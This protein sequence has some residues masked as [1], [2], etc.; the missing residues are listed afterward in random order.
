MHFA[1][2][3]ETNTNP[4]HHRLKEKKTSNG[5][6]RGIHHIYF[7]SAARRNNCNSSDRKLISIRGM[8]TSLRTR[9]TYLVQR[10]SIVIHKQ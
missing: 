1:T 3:T 4:V 2:T 5:E 9:F 8:E 6:M 10:Q 7:F